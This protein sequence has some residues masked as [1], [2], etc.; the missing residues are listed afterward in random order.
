MLL[1]E[2]Y[3]SPKTP[4]MR[5]VV[6]MVKSFKPHCFY[7]CLTWSYALYKHTKVLSASAG[8]HVH[9]LLIMVVNHPRP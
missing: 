3:L 8:R 2:I 5:V 4:H 9:L 6:M 1:G 7:L